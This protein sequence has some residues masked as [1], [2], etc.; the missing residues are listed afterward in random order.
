MSDLTKVTMNFRPDSIE[1]L[2]DIAKRFNRSN[3]TDANAYAID[4][5]DYLGKRLENGEKLIVQEKDGT[6]RELVI[7][8]KA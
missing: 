6:L 2:G 5:A 3:R 4:L 8:E 7:P 1:K